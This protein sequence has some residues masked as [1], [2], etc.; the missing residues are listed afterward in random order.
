[1][2]VRPVAVAVALC[3]L[4]AGCAAPTVSPAADAVDG[5]EPRSAGSGSAESPTADRSPRTAVAERSGRSAPHGGGT[6]EASS[7]PSAEPGSPAA[8]AD[9]YAIAVE[10]G[11]LP[12]AYAPVFARV[13]VLTGRPTVTPPDRVAIRSPDRMR[14][15]RDRYPEFY[16]LVGVAAGDGNGTAAAFVGSAGTVTVNA[17]VLADA[18]D[19]ESVLAHESVHVIQFRDGAFA[20]LR[21]RGAVAP[22]TT[23]ARLLRTAVV[24]GSATAVQRAYVERYGVDAPDPVAAL[25]ARAANGSTAERLGLAPYVVGARYVERRV[26]DWAT[27]ASVYES[28]PRT[29]EELLHDR[30]PGSEPVAPLVVEDDPTDEWDAAF[31]ERDTHG[32]LFLRVVLAGE[33]PDS[34]AA[35]GAD[36]WG[37]D[38]RLAFEH[39]TERG[40]V[41][42]GYAWVIRF[43]DA[44]NATEFERAFG[45]WR[46][47]RPDGAGAVRAVRPADRT[48]AVFVGNESF[49]ASASAAGT[50]GRVTVGAAG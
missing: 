16:R 49:V 17:A 22:G 23:E 7:T 47:A 11:E 9:G 42:T 2:S 27:L 50:D 45:A 10:G 35:A 33:L 28:P 4:L 18:G 13:A 38:V 46:D 29:T 12:T 44:A 19:T 5:D 41:A 15:G 36:G 40:A 48:V 30:P 8:L 20:R 43:D 32:E 26:D 14:V 3:L 31:G 39:E 6:P 34:R 24:E 21:D 25:G 1:M 37:N